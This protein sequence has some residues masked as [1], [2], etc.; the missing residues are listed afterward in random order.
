MP[1]TFPGPLSRREAEVLPQLC[2]GAPP[3]QIAARLFISVATA[4]NHVK[5]ILRKLGVHTSL[6]AVAWASRHKLS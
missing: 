4:R 5:S 3:Q 2:E 6:E 1:V